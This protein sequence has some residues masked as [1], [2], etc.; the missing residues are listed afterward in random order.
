MESLWIYNRLQS[1]HH[2]FSP[3]IYESI[4][5]FKKYMNINRSGSGF[6]LIEL[7]VTISIIG[8]LGAL[9]VPIYKTYIIKAKILEISNI[10]SH[11]A[12]ASGSFYQ[13]YNRWPK[14]DQ[15]FI[16][17]KDTLNIII[18]QNKIE[19]INA[20]GNPFI[21]SV[22]IKNVS[23]SNPEI[24]GKILTLTGNILPNGAIDWQW[25]GTLESK[26]IPKK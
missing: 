21:I 13:E 10:M 5:S 1:I 14:C 6:T 22:K 18:P 17:I 7:M 16:S 12:S 3:Y 8:I 15:S 20:E 24:D 19:S 4:R 26:F 25:G 2:H 11:V 23:K 9:A